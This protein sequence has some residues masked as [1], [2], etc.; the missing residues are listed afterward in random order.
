V[1]DLAPPEIDELLPKERVLGDKTGAPRR[2]A[3]P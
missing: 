2:P 1:D 3:P